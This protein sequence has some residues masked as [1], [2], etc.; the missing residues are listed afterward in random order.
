[1]IKNYNDIPPKKRKEEDDWDDDEDWDDEEDDWEDYDDGDWENDGDF[2]DGWDS[3]LEEN[4]NAYD[5]YDYE[6]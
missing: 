5:P 1:M 3:D 2:E 4:E 6:Y